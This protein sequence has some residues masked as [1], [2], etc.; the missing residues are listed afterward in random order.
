M[1]IEQCRWTVNQGWEPNSPNS[2]QSAHLVLVFGGTDILKTENY[3][4]YFRQIYPNATI[5]GCSTA[6]EICDTQVTDDAIVV[7]AIEFE[8][9]QIKGN[10]LPITKTSDSFAIGAKLAQSFPTEDLVHLFVLSD[11]L[12]VNGSDLI[13]G[14]R[15]QLPEQVTV[16]GGLAGDGSRFAETLIF[17]NELLEKELVAAIGIYGDR[18]KIGYGSLGGWATFG[19]KR[20]VTKSQGNILYELD[21]L[22]ALELYKKYLG[23][24]AVGLPASGLLFPLSLYNA[25]GDRSVVRTILSI[26]EAEQ[27]LTFAGDVPEGSVVQ[28]MQTNFERLVDGAIGAAQTSISH[29]TQG[30]PDLAILISCV[31]RKLVLKQRIEEEVDGVREVMGQSTVLTGFYSYGE[32]AP[33]SMGERC[34]LHNQTM[35]ITT[36]SE[37]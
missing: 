30:S 35:T 9:T 14:L 18:I 28:L 24:H 26:D 12:I 32:M 37:Q 16:T 29:M 22:S 25:E 3:P 34:E 20:V 31:G 11:G 1:K 33:T 8:H 10:Y 6:G 2:N 7:T 21:G 15:S 19:P 36:F 23:D 17:W 13:S 5:I 4:Q 27:S